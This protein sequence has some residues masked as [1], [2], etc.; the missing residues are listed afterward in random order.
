MR[1]E[2]L[3]HLLTAINPKTICVSG[4]GGKSSFLRL[5][6]R[7]Y[8][9]RVVLTTTTH[10]GE[11]Q[12][13]LAGSHVI[14][15]PGDQVSQELLAAD[16]PLL[17]TAGK[18]RENKWCALSPEQLQDLHA[19]CQRTRSV[20]VIEADGSRGLPVKAPGEAEPVIPAFTD[21]WVYVLGLSAIGKPLHEQN[22]HR[23]ELIAKRTGTRLGEPITL[24]TLI[25]LF[26]SPLAG[27]KAAPDHSKRIAI[28]NQMDLCQIPEPAILA[29]VSRVTFAGYDHFWVG[30]LR[31]TRNADKETTLAALNTGT[32]PGHFPKTSAMMYN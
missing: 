8:P 28:L 10:L 24:K 4:A 22:A 3:L 13:D 2:E 7:E 20:L 6:A 16:Q 11:K 32:E 5:M 21:L 1:T 23:P 27:L 26:I 25:D 15:E 19:L 12:A 14:L 29:E 30:S 17:V 31:K 18:N 9:G